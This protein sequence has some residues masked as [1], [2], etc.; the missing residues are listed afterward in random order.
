MGVPVIL[1]GWYKRMMSALSASR[2][3][4]PTLEY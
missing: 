4:S 1:N 3:K 2:E